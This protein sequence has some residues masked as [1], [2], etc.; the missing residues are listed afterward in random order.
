[1][2]VNV[3]AHIVGVGSVQRG[4][5]RLNIDGVYVK[6][7]S[8]RMPHIEQDKAKIILDSFAENVANVATATLQQ[9]A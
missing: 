3:E 8:L 2:Q 7:F 5:V 6:I 9:V 1:M 4:V